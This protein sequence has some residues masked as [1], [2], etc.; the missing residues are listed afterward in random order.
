MRGASVEA[1]GGM[2]AAPPEHQ[3][4]EHD[5]SEEY[6]HTARLQPDD[7]CLAIQ[8]VR[9]GE[10]VA[11]GGDMREKALLLIAAASGVELLLEHRRDQRGF[12]Q[13]LGKLSLRVEDI[14]RGIVRIL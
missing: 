3:Q 5:A 7:D 8:S 4:K 6:Q 1:S 11:D 9:G 14:G 10:A 12:G 13:Q 2:A